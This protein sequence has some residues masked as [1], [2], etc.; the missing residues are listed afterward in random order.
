MPAGSADTTPPSSLPPC[1][2]AV[3]VVHPDASMHAGAEPRPGT[4]QL[5]ASACGVP[6]DAVLRC[7][8]LLGGAFAVSLLFPVGGTRMSPVTLEG[9]ERSRQQRE[10][11]GQARERRTETD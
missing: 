11:D 1:G 3:A 7:R 6:I 8:Q 4:R 5:L 2:V 10:T 9:E